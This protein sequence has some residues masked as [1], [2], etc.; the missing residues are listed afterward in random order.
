[1]TTQQQG[2]A[3]CGQGVA[4]MHTEARVTEQETEAHLCASDAP[5]SDG[6]LCEAD[7]LGILARKLHMQRLLQQC[8]RWLQARVLTY[9]AG[10]RKCGVAN[11]KQ[12]IYAC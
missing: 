5:G 9:T 3:H 2:K 8:S 11:L 7:L 12:C 4:D 10:C 1:M 6:D